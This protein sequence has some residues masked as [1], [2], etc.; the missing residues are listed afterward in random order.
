MTPHEH[1][2]EAERQLDA[3]DRATTNG[4][5]Y[6]AERH[7]RRARVHAILATAPRPPRRRGPYSD[8]ELRAGAADARGTTDDPLDRD[9]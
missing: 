8:E 1:Y 3:S 6:W 2:L 9:T 4:D 7:V 5:H